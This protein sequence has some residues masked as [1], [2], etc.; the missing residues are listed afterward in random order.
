MSG[1]DAGVFEGATLNRQ[2]N[3]LIQRFT[4][5]GEIRETPMRYFAFLQPCIR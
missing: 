5:E 3:L 2:A 4:H 1:Q